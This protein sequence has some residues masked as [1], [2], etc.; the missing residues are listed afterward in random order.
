VSKSNGA[1]DDGSL[2][3]S[4]KRLLILMDHSLD[5]VELLGRGGTIEGVSAAIKTLGGY[6]PQDLVGRHYQDIIHPDD[7]ARTASAFARALNGEAVGIV[8]FRYLRKDGSWRTV[9]ATARNFLADPAVHAVV[10]LTR[11]LTDQRAAESHLAEANSEL[12]RLAQQLI[13]AHEDE[14]G[15][16]A[17]ELHDDVQQ[18]LVGLR[19]GMGRSH[20]APS[21]PPE[22]ALLDSWRELVDLAI[23]HL[24]N[25]TLTLRPPAID[26]L[27]L[28]SELRALADRLG[29]AS[30]RSIVLD[31][32]SSI[33][34]IRPDVQLACF[35]IVQEALANAIKHSGAKHLRVALARKDHELAVTIHDDGPGFDV[36]AAR[37]Q[38]LAGG[39]VGFLSMRER[40]SL[41][42]GRLEIHSAAGSGTEVCA[43]FPVAE[44]ATVASAS[45][46]A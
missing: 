34:R 8:T 27:G 20:P 9:E 31:I 44:R 29:A 12:H 13:S 21:K 26:Q 43:T 30:G 32:G 2:T 19:L 3:L 39:R 16:L 14:R 4:P 37:A 42:G 15:H 23:D 7:C 25:L 11:D 41:A 36:A 5:F 6:D 28:G 33:D 46:D 38:A 45:V 22:P 35:R 40:A 10:V 1:R 18:I 24:H 17:R